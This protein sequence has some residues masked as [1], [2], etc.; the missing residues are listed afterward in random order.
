MFILFPDPNAGIDF[1]TGHE[2]YL[3]RVKEFI[4]DD[5]IDAEILDVSKWFINEIVAEFYSDGNM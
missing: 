3:K 4:G 5:T 1:T 2:Q